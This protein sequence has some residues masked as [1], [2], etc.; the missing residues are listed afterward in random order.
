MLATIQVTAGAAAGTLD[1]LAGDVQGVAVG[2]W[3]ASASCAV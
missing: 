2:L 3:Q 1:R